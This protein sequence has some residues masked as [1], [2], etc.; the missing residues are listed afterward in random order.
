M[1]ARRTFARTQWVTA[2]SEDLRSRALRLG[3]SNLQSEVIPYGVDIDRF[4]PNSDARLQLRS[5]HSLTTD[6]CI[7]LCVGRL[8]R[9]KGF[10]YLIDAVASLAKQQPTIRLVVA[11]D[12][13]LGRELRERADQRNIADR[14]I[15]LGAITQQEVAD[16]LAVADIVAVPS[17]RDSA[18]NVD[19]LPNVVL[20]ALASA[21]PVITTT[22]GGIGSVAIDHETALVVPEQDAN[23]LAEAI[24]TLRTDRSLRITIGRTAREYVRTHNS[25]THLAERLESVYEKAVQKMVPS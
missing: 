21:T 13:D 9:K 23:A 7:V 4:Q 20:E 24:E 25:W 14:I 15:W 8:V 12:G 6:H 10:E 19:G 17:V 22:A 18:G 11:G 1:A 16:W 2:C 3:A 5:T